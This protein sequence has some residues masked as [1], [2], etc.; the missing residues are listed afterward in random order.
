MS[1]AWIAALGHRSVLVRIPGVNGGRSV[2]TREHFPATLETAI[3]QKTR[4]LLGIALSGWDR[5]GWRDGFANRYMLLRDRKTIVAPLIAAFGYLAAAAFL[6]DFALFASM[7]AGHRFA[8]VVTAHSTLAALL[9]VNG[10]TLGWRLGLRAYFTGRTHGWREGARALPRSLVSNWINGVAAVR[11]LRRY[12]R[13][14]SGR[15]QP[16]WEKTAHKFT[17]PAE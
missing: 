2:A 11:A 7:P 5:I 15:E 9:L 14:R 6:A 8:P 17:V 12:S 10:L 16:V 13:L 1:S 4:W 3:R